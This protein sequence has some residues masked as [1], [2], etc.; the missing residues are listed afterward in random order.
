M[1]KLTLILLALFALI[2]IVSGQ[3]QLN[4]ADLE[5]RDLEAEESDSHRDLAGKK[6]SKRDLKRVKRDLRKTK[7]DLTE[8]VQRDLKR[9]AKRALEVRDLIL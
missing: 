8:N 2:V 3:D 4:Q 9:A 6:A 7:R 1:N 5:F